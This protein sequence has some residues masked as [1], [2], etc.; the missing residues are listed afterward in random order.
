MIPMTTFL[1][2]LRLSFYNP[3][4]ILSRKL[5]TKPVDGKIK[6]SSKQAYSDVN[7]PSSPG[8]RKL[9]KDGYSSKSHVSYAERDLTP[10]EYRSRVSRLHA[11]LDK[12]RC[13]RPRAKRN[14][15]NFKNR[16]NRRKNFVRKD[17]LP[18]DF[19][20]NLPPPVKVHPSKFTKFAYVMA[21]HSLREDNKRRLS[22]RRRLLRARLRVLIPLSFSNWKVPPRRYW[23]ARFRWPFERVHVPELRVTKSRRF[24]SLFQRPYIPKL[25]RKFALSYPAAAVPYVFSDIFSSFKA[26]ARYRNKIRNSLIFQRRRQKFGWPKRKRVKRKW[27]WKRPET[28][29]IFGYSSRKDRRPLPK[30]RFIQPTSLSKEPLNPSPSYRGEH[31]PFS[32]DELQ[33]SLLKSIN[34]S[35]KFSDRRFSWIPG[36]WGPV[37][38]KPRRRLRVSNRLKRLSGMFVRSRAFQAFKK[39]KK[40]RLIR[41]LFLSFSALDRRSVIRRLPRYRVNRGVYRS[42]PSSRGKMHYPGVAR[43]SKRSFFHISGDHVK[44]WRRYADSRRRRVG[45]FVLFYYG[46][47]EFMSFAVYAKKQVNFMSFRKTANNFFITV[48]KRSGQLILSRSVGI[49]KLKGPRRSTVEAA[50]DLMAKVIA[51]LKDKRIRSVNILLRTKRTSRHIRAVLKTFKKLYPTGIGPLFLRLPARSHN[52]LRSKKRTRG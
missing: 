44:S 31:S 40:I 2:P 34:T 21:S 26:Y 51:E 37:L 10:E 36:M 23:R 19:Y 24:L 41:A 6:S 49:L 48:F 7:K 22:R 28:F 3:F 18:S 1:I 39:S 46:R 20:S 43:F 29:D 16:L 25:A 11:I 32:G 42:V 5:A 9:E 14:H 12:K 17:P 52:G 13:E 38:V 33:N 30:L 8:P 27:W 47:K 15:Y 4:F 50:S 45:R 35:S